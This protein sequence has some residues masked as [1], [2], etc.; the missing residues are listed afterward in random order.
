MEIERDSIVLILHDGTDSQAQ[1][2]TIK[3]D[4]TKGAVTWKD[5]KEWTAIEV[6]CP[7]TNNIEMMMNF[8]SKL[9]Y[10]FKGDVPFD[11]METKLRSI[12]DCR[13]FLFAEDVTKSKYFRGF[14]AYKGGNPTN[15]V[16][17]FSIKHCRET[18]ALDFEE[19]CRDPG[20]NMNRLKTAGMA[21]VTT[22]TRMQAT[23]YVNQCL[24]YEE[25]LCVKIYKEELFAEIQKVI[26][27]EPYKSKWENQCLVTF[28]CNNKKIIPKRLAQQNAGEGRWHTKKTVT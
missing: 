11:E 24:N 16:I 19:G 10:R 3:D 5:S 18:A 21:G 26:E 17:G 6:L 8:I 27:T 23:Q 12:P 2:I 14:A 25:E 22:N 7:L 15:Y 28:M 20:E 4:T 9:V 13:F 1:Q